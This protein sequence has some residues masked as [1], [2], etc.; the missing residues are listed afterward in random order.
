MH[1]RPRAILRRIQT[2]AAICAVVPL[3]AYALLS[4]LT[5]RPGGPAE[6]ALPELRSRITLPVTAQAQAVRFH[7]QTV[8]DQVRMLQA[9]ANEVLRAPEIYAGPQSR[10]A[11]ISDGTAKVGAKP[12]SPAAASEDTDTKGETSFVPPA[13]PAPGLDNPLLYTKG[14]DGAIRKLIDDGRPA[15]FFRARGSGSFTVR[16][17]QRLLAS[18]ALD[19]LLKQTSSGPLACQAFLLTSD[20]LLRTAPFRDLAGME[21]ARDLTQTP[22]F[23]WKADKAGKRGVVWTAPYPSPLCNEWVIAALAGV[24]VNGK[25]VAVVGAEVPARA[26][27]EHALTF[28]LGADSLSWLMRGDGV[29]LAAPAGSESQLGLKALADTDLPDEEQAGRKLLEAANLYLKGT[30]ELSGRLADMQSSADVA[31]E[32]VKFGQR[33]MYLVSAPVEAT[34]LRLGALLHSPLADALEREQQQRYSIFGRGVLSLL[35]ALAVAALLVLAASTIVARRITIPLTLLT[36]KVRQA[37]SSGRKV[38]VAIADDSE[39]GTLSKAVQ[40]LVDRLP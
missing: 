9:Y 24:Q 40:D 14:A 21:A 36:Q 29:L 31:V 35:L 16:D 26:L 10:T 34:D 18:A 1:S 2:A 23:A 19:P 20:S 22:L 25:L 30:R 7:L 8:E 27:Q 5:P 12:A 6:D 38:P 32:V 11:A 13:L 15:V 39:V 33:N 28:P 37:A 4:S 3:L 17:K